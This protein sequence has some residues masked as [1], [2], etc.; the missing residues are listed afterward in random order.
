MV[1]YLGPHP[2]KDLVLLAHATFTNE[3]FIRAKS[4]H[5][6]RNQFETVRMVKRFLPVK[7]HITKEKNDRK[8]IFQEIALRMF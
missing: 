6:R 8:Y 2:L 7:W 4:F 1:E 5:K 3:L